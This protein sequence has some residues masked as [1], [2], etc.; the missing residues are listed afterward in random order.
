MEIFV[1][2]PSRIFRLTARQACLRPPSFSGPLHSFA[3]K[4]VSLP[5][6]A[7]AFNGQTLNMFKKESRLRRNGDRLIPSN[8]WSGR[9]PPKVSIVP[10]HMYAQ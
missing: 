8:A 5:R 6:R 3:R 1:P 9:N 2:I 10:I 7:E 4:R